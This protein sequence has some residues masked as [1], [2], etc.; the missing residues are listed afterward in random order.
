M[1]GEGGSTKFAHAGRRHARVFAGLDALALASS[2]GLAGGIRRVWIVRMG[3]WREAALE[4]GQ[5]LGQAHSGRRA[6]VPW[7]AGREKG[8]GIW[9]GGTIGSEASLP[10]YLPIHPPTLP[11]Y[12]PS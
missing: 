11:R 10:T 6:E 7:Q 5:D 1:E 3:K 4:H 12:L 9:E 2:S 8:K